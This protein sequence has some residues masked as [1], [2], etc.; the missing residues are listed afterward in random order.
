MGKN[1]KNFF[2]KSFLYFEQELCQHF[3]PAQT[4]PTAL[5]F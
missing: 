5:D 4:V 3:L 2:K 1:G